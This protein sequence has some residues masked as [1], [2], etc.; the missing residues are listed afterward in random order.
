MLHSL[1][2]LFNFLA[3]SYH[4]VSCSKKILKGRQAQIERVR[5]GKRDLERWWNEYRQEVAEKRNGIGWNENERK[6]GVEFGKHFVMVMIKATPPTWLCINLRLMPSR[7]TWRRP[8][9]PVFMSCTGNSP[10]SSGPTHMEKKHIAVRKKTQLSLFQQQEAEYHISNN[11]RSKL[12]HFHWDDCQ[13][14]S[15]LTEF[16][17]QTHALQFNSLGSVRIDTFYS[18]KTQYIVYKQL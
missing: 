2:W 5:G 13:K 4:F 15:I 11:T 10:P 18:E 14:W 6:G 17:L 16:T 7:V 12:G 8:P 9:S 1:I 3:R